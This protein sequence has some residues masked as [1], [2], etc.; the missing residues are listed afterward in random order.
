MDENKTLHLNEPTF[1]YM[2]KFVGQ[3]KSLNLPMTCVFGY[4]KTG[5]TDPTK[6]WTMKHICLRNTTVKTFM[7]AYIN[8]IL[9]KN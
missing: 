3:S 1:E 7:D 8:S 2:N 9:F 4:E 5:H 6:A